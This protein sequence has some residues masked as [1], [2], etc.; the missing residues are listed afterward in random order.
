LFN[1]AFNVI[2]KF[3]SKKMFDPITTLFK[4]SSPLAWGIGV[5][6]LI[7]LGLMVNKIIPKFPVKFAFIIILLAIL[8]VPIMFVINRLLPSNDR[9][10]EARRLTLILHEPG[11]KNLRPLNNRGRVELRTEGHRIEAAI[12]EK[13]YAVYDSL[14]DW[15]FDDKLGVVVAVLP[16]IVDSIYSSPDM[17][18]FFQ[19]NKEYYIELLKTTPRKPIK[20]DEATPSTAEKS[21]P[22]ESQSP[23]KAEKSELSLFFV[24][25]TVEAKMPL[26]FDK[27]KTL[28]ELQEEI[29]TKFKKIINPQY[30]DLLTLVVNKALITP[31]DKS[32]SLVKYGMKDNDEIAIIKASLMLK[33]FPKTTF[34]FEGIKF[35]NPVV[36]IDNNKVENIKNEPIAQR[37][38]A[39]GSIFNPND[40]CAI[41]II[42]GSLRYNFKLFVKDKTEIRVDMTKYKA[43]DF[44]KLRLTTN[45]QRIVKASK[46][47]R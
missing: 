40:S 35:L 10:P 12:D 42:D 28:A 1:K 14:P 36:Y 23:K 8:L 26:E 31:S 7:V 18:R 11:D 5:I 9:R 25:T 22:K 15:A 39:I 37:L 30:G 27:H 24:S 21:K 6:A 47:Y 32:L 13:G 2:L 34:Y 29:K 43:L 33:T 4:Q 38:T 16:S 19:P 41:R 20:S 45:I 46:Q 3:N 17:W 44:S